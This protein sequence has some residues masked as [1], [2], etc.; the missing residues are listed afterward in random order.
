MS[1]PQAFVNADEVDEPS[2]DL[3]GTSAGTAGA[4]T[5]VMERKE[6]KA[7]KVLTAVASKASGK[8]VPHEVVDMLSSRVKEVQPELDEIGPN[9]M[10][11]LIGELKL[12][13]ML[14]G[15]SGLG[16]KN[17]KDVGEHKVCLHRFRYLALLLSELSRYSFGKH[18]PCH[19]PV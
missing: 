6:S 13:D 15:R 16:G 5:K 7:A 17:K 10:R 19:S 14:D 9:E 1:D 8:K 18:S 4:D 12:K 3:P 2:Q 11:K